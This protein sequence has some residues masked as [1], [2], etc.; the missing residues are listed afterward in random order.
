MTM[1]RWIVAG[2]F[3]WALASPVMAFDSLGEI[4]ADLAKCSGCLHRN[5]LQ[6]R[7]NYRLKMIQAAEISMAG[8][9]GRVPGTDTRMRGAVAGVAGNLAANAGIN[10]SGAPAPS[11]AA[12]EALRG[13]TAM[14]AYVS[15][16]GTSEINPAEFRLSIRQRLRES[17]VTSYP[18]S[19]PVIGFQLRR[20]GGH[21]FTSQDHHQIRPYHAPGLRNQTKTT[22]VPTATYDVSAEFRRLVPGTTTANNPIRDEALWKIASSGEVGQVAAI[23]IADEAL[24]QAI[25]FVD[26][27][28]SVN[29]RRPAITFKAKQ[30]VTP[31][32][33]PQTNHP[34]IVL[35]HETVQPLF[36]GA[37]DSV[38]DV[39]QSQ[40][41]MV[42][43]QLS[44]LAAGGQKVLTCQYG[45]RNAVTPVGFKDYSFW[46]PAPP[47]DLM[48]YM[49]S[50][51]GHPFMRL[52]LIS[53]TKCPSTAA[54]AELLF[55][56]RFN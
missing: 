37:V 26:S 13:Q 29:P 53:V 6:A 50:T 30:P 14:S 42:E 18:Y 52:G 8:I 39:H 33:P 46:Y 7:L 3:T 45:P 25:Q 43:K 48:K 9:A 23:G 28:A 12:Q 15:V 40:R 51:F 24:K 17:A 22:S 31:G 4:K 38:Y 16:Y 19:A 20:Q 44:S 5:L 2:C 55:R 54:G 49:L 34:E 47:S 56:Q 32:S 10:G 41:D 35:L 27:W 11:R 36:K 1:A 21:R